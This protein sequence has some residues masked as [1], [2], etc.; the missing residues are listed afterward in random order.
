MYD[1]W[2]TES[3]VFQTEYTDRNSIGYQINR[4]PEGFLEIGQQVALIGLDSEI[5]DAI[6][7]DLFRCSF[8]FSRLQFF[9][10]GNIRKNTPEFMAQLFA[11]LD[12]KKMNLIILGADNQFTKTITRLISA[13]ENIAVIGKTMDS[14]TE[15]DTLSDLIGNQYIEKIKLIAFQSHLVHQHEI[16]RPKMNQSMSLG[17]LRN[18]MRDAEPTLRD[19]SLTAFELSSIRYGEIPGIPGTTPSGL[20]S[21]E[22]CQL[23]KYIGLNPLRNKLWIQGYNPKYDFH[24]QG[25]KMVSQLV[26]YYLEGLD[27]MVNEQPDRKFLTQYTVAMSD[28]QINL[29]FWKSEISGR[30]WVEV[31]L[32]DGEPY[33]LPCSFMDYKIACNDEMPK[34][35]M[36]E[37]SL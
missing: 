18:N 21:E 22:A 24:H 25:A 6:R 26:W 11:E 14:L 5:A 28:Y 37:L 32:K 20:S 12:A 2:F 10:F 15:F 36:N 19:V 7:R 16:N 31:P 9:D 3:E 13:Q 8:N 33:L 4:E 29:N 30:W 34:R 23:M 1:N 27:Q 35:I 17:S